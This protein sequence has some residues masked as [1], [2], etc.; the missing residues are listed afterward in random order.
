VALVV[1]RGAGAAAA[2]G[3]SPLAVAVA[4]AGAALAGSAYAEVRALSRSEHPLTIVLWFQ[5]AC[6]LLS[7]PG[8]LVGGPVL[9][10]GLDLAWLAGV[11]VTAAAGQ[12]CLTEGLRRLPAGRAT[13]ANPLVVAFGAALG[14]LLFG[15]SLGPEVLA[16]AA[17]LV[18]GLLLAGL[19]R[20][21]P[22]VAATA[23]A[24]AP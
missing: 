2:G 11:G 19:G 17:L 7:L 6:V 20:P 12:S 14:A 1:P 24:S 15:E 18:A 22:G 16:G 13:L 5:G 9:P 4:L 8:T 23:G 21:R 10:R 3:G